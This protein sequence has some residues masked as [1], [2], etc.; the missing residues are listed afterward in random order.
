[1]ISRLNWEETINMGMKVNK[2]YIEWAVVTKK[3]I[4]FRSLF[5][6]CPKAIKEKWYERAIIKSWRIKVVVN[7]YDLDRIYIPYNKGEEYTECFILRNPRVNKTEISN[8]QAI[9]QL[10]KVLRMLE[11]N[12]KARGDRNNVR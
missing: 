5:Y 10:L 1:M 11:R 4:R 2:D 6:S 8:Y 9:L 7:P 12:S 3:G